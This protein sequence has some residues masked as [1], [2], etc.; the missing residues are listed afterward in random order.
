M[1][2]K[3]HVALST[4]Y[5]HRLGRIGISKCAFCSCQDSFLRARDV[6]ASSVSFRLISSSQVFL[7]SSI[8]FHSLPPLLF[9]MSG[10]ITVRMTSRT[11]TLNSTRLTLPISPWTPTRR[12]L[13]PVLTHA[14]PRSLTLTRRHEPPSGSLT[15]ARPLVRLRPARRRPTIPAVQQWYHPSDQAKG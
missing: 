2:A 5:L 14:R 7:V 11:L 1:C 9:P 10:K 8:H 4:R 3:F 13:L 6:F 12:L 15:S